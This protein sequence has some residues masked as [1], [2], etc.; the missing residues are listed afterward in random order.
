METRSRS[1]S[2]PG[3]HDLRKRPRVIDLS[4]TA[5]TGEESPRKKPKIIDMVFFSTSDVLDQ[6]GGGAADVKKQHEIEEASKEKVNRVSPAPPRKEIVSGFGTSAGPMVFS[7]VVSAT[8]NEVRMELDAEQ[9]QT[10]DRMSLLATAA[11]VTTPLPVIKA[12]GSGNSSSSNASGNGRPAVLLD[13][14]P[15]EVMT[16][17]A[18]LLQQPRVE[19]T[20][21]TVHLGSATPSSFQVPAVMPAFYTEEGEPVTLQIGDLCVFSCK[22]CS[23]KQTSWGKMY[24]HIEKCHQGFTDKIVKKDWILRRVFHQCQVCKRN[25]NCERRAISVHVFNHQLTLKDYIEKFPSVVEEV[26]SE[27]VTD[28]V[29]DKVGNNCRY[30]CQ[31]CSATHISWEGMYYHIKNK[32]PDYK[33]KIARRDWMC[34]RM[35]HRCQICKQ[36]VDCD[37]RAIKIHLNYHNMTIKSYI[38][39]FKLTVDEDDESQVDLNIKDAPV[40]QLGVEESF[41]GGSLVDSSANVPEL[42]IQVSKPSVGC[43]PKAQHIFIE[44]ALPPVFLPTVR[45]PNQVGFNS[46]AKTQAAT[47]RGIVSLSLERKDDANAMPDQ[48]VEGPLSIVDSSSAREEGGDTD[49]TLVVGDLCVFSCKFCSFSLTCWLKMY[50]HIEIKHQEYENKIVKK[51]FLVKVVH[52][53]CQVCMKKIYCERKA[54]CSHMNQRHKLTLQEYIDKFPQVTEEETQNEEEDFPITCKVGNLCQYS[55]QLCK[56]ETLSWEHMYAHIKKNHGQFR[57]KIQRQE[58]MSKRV[59]HQCQVCKRK[60]DCDRR[61]IK[62]HVYY[63]QLSLQ[64]YTNKYANESKH[65]N[66]LNETEDKNRN[67]KILPEP[68][69]VEKTKNSSKEMTSYNLNKGDADETKHVCKEEA[70]AR[71]QEGNN[72]QVETDSRQEPKDISGLLKV[73]DLC[74]FSCK[75]CPLRS[76]TWQKMHRHIEIKHQNFQDKIVKSDFMSKTVWHEC[77]VC[78]KHIYCERKAIASHIN[79]H[80]LTIQKYI[81]QHPCLREEDATFDNM[82]CAVTSEINN[83]CEYACL[84]CGQAFGSWEQTYN[85]IKRRHKDY[86]GKIDRQEWMTKKVLHRCHMCGQKVDCDHKAIKSHAYYH[87]LSLQQY[88]DKFSGR[89]IKLEADEPRRVEEISC[90]EEVPEVKTENDHEDLVTTTT[91]VIG[92]DNDDDDKGENAVEGERTPE[93]RKSKKGKSAVA[94]TA[95]SREDE[96]VMTKRVGDLCMFSCRFCPFSHRVWQRLRRHIRA[97]HRSECC[98]AKKA[99]SSS[100]PILKKGDFVRTPATWHECQECGRPV[101]CERKSVS[102]HVVQRHGM[103]LSEYVSRHA[104]VTEDDG[105]EEERSARV[106]SEE[107]DDLCLYACQMCSSHQTNSWDAMVK[108]IRLYHRHV[109]Q[110]K[111]YE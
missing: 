102:I 83:L 41:G 29:T 36:F 39:K 97:R 88:V 46:G 19:S 98:G 44:K 23:E 95:T 59:L 55:C 12:V 73:G 99:S 64:E 24:Q 9:L 84:L 7:K 109:P 90:K 26:V 100:V 48:D 89:Q 10:M 20:T 87:Q 105:G 21:P 5:T 82:D 57:K 111:S 52:H 4:V 45:V 56:V 43:V 14:W 80:R 1:S 42:K 69:G 101:L 71:D 79:R 110:N 27:K 22:F 85:H 81:D 49:T 40:G 106:F 104:D 75:F 11:S 77:Q 31:V 54:I 35:L 70:G 47:A 91:L 32:H 78:H 103:S 37:R 16:K 15:E 93:A 61:A 107:V 94:V 108:H 76:A 38:E 96:K 72:P 63:H 67:P 66:P 17:Q 34:Q 33:K 60:V 51:D 58:W 62:A 50:R 68:S 92:S 8:S 18:V 65:L 2:L 6:G 28:P 30:E 3:F 13:F 25:L 74:E 53:Q 86:S